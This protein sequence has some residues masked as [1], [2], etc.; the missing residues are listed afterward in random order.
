MELHQLKL[1]TFDQFLVRGLVRNQLFSRY[2]SPVLPMHLGFE[3]KIILL[4]PMR[5]KPSFSILPRRCEVIGCV[6][7]R[8]LLPFDH[9]TFRS[10][11]CDTRFKSRQVIHHCPC[12]RYEAAPPIKANLT[13][14][15]VNFL[16]TVPSFPHFHFQVRNDAATLEPVW[17][18]AS[19][20][21]KSIEWEILS[22][23]ST[24]ASIF[25]LPFCHSSVTRDGL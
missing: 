9:P 19:F 2:N 24:H 25:H 20:R 8:F 11:T 6:S 16:L 3:R 18:L 13:G 10:A 15:C 14:A 17:S 1:S 5:R 22:L 4:V 12:L 21:A 7:L 23:S